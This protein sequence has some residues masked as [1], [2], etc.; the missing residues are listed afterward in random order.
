MLWAL[1]QG[2]LVLIVLLSLLLIAHPRM[3]DADLRALVFTS[4]VLMNLGLILVNRSFGATLKDAVLRPNRSLWLL[5]GSVVSLLALSLFWPPLRSLFQFGQLH[6]DDLGL[7]AL[8]GLFSLLVLEGLKSRW[9][10]FT[11][12]IAR[13]AR[14]G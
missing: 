12:T 9:F 13:P 1:I 7:C 6:W 2:L 5:I 11:R 10:G 8:M 3:P 4:L 14:L